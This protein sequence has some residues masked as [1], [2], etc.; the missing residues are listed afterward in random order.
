MRFEGILG[1]GGIG[2]VYRARDP[3]LRRTVAIKALLNPDVDAGKFMRYGEV[4]ARLQH[5]NIVTVLNAL[6]G[7]NQEMIGTLK[8]RMRPSP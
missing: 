5:P 7:Q 3:Y 6:E 2:V 1:R 8:A 4:L